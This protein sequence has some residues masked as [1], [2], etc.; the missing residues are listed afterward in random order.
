MEYLESGE[1]MI[2]TSFYSSPVGNILLAQK[3]NALIGLWIEGQKYFLSSLKEEQ[4]VN[5]DC[6]ILI[7]TK[8]WLDR[9][10][11]G[12]KPDIGEL[13]LAPAGSGFRQA[14]WKILCA[15]PYGSVTTYGEIARQIAAQKGLDHMSA[16]AIGGAVGHNPISIIIPCHRV[17]GT[18]GSLTGY[19]G[20]IDKKM[21]LLSHEGLDLEDRSLFRRN[22]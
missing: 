20:G 8:R 14:V 10:F 11:A 13:H 2:E 9:Y 12:E 16:Q 21:W 15:I 1:S 5:H 22:L 4:T 17:V 6:S 18:N 3:N 7:D 19:A